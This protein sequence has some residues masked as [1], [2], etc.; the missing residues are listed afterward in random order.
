[1]IIKFKI[2][3]KCM[4]YVNLLPPGFHKL[5]SF[6]DKS[7]KQNQSSEAPVQLPKIF[8]SINRTTHF[9]TLVRV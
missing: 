8:P 3:K 9:K 1:M 6:E 5:E 2:D 4:L 7:S